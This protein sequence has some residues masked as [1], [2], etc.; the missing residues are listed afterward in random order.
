[1]VAPP[2]RRPAALLYLLLVVLACLG[3]AAT[4]P[5]QRL[6]LPAL[7]ISWRLL[8]QLP[9]TIDGATG[10]APEV[11]IV[12]IDEAAIAA[13]GKPFALMQGELAVL[14]DGLRAGQAR[15]V[16]LDLILPAR[17]HAAL[18]PGA[19]RQLALALAAVR[20]QVPLV[21]GAMPASAVAADDAAP[22][23]AAIAG[24][25]GL[26]SLH[27]PQDADGVLRRAPLAG[28][29][30]M[31]SLSAQLAA[32]LGVVARAGL[33]DFRHGAR[34]DYVPLPHVLA[35]RR[36]GDRQGLRQLFA[37]RVVLIGAILPDQDR[38]R[39]PVAMAAW[40]PG[41]V[42][43]G[44]VFQAQLLRS[45]LSRR[46]VQPAPWLE[47][48]GAL[49]AGMLIWRLR[50]RPLAASASGAGLAVLGTLLSLCCLAH[51]LLVS[52]LACLLVLAAGVAWSSWRAYREQRAGQRRLRAIFAGYVSP[53][54]L[55]TILSGDLRA[56]LA[57]QRQP[58]AFLFADL[59]GFTAMC[60]ALPPEQVIASLNRYYAAITIPLHRHGGTIDK[61]SGD[62]VMVFF[63]AP[64]P[65]AHPCR[66]ALLAAHG[67]LEALD[68]LNAEL[69]REG[70]A[71]MLAGIGI[72]YGDAVLGNVGT[73]ERHDYTATGFAAALAAHIQ[74]LCK[75]TP[76]ALLMERS[77]LEHAALAPEVAARYALIERHIDK[78]GQV[79]LA[80]YSHL[81]GSSHA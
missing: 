46:M 22:L 25:A 39:L 9:G 10:T 3:L 60:A 61:F 48:A 76:Y 13:S 63:G 67:V 2:W 77:V 66:D 35:L 65:S 24:D 68:I 51:G 34:F 37:G 30:G 19:S 57:S 16:G 52:P 7:D 55:D 17:S 15:A 43:A 78:H 49:L 80:A 28:E 5:L 72:A 73:A 75:N 58:L 31:P 8:R 42:T 20:D 81:K 27:V 44:V 33:V 64:A 79:A 36:S 50:H 1:M 21:I 53:A 23:Y 45:Q 32:S 18:L 62:G 38:Q 70:R 14:L 41:T 29:H 6:A 59:R 54:I 47:A 71:P 56:G 40:E 11:V 26:A 69:A 4:P 12:G 74:Q